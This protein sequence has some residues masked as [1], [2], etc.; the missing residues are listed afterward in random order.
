MAEQ[1]RPRLLLV[2]ARPRPG[3]L[4]ELRVLPAAEAV[5]GGQD[6]EEASRHIDQ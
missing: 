5:L 4:G 3:T 1:G 2:V 6:A